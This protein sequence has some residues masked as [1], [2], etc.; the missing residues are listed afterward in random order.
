MIGKPL[1]ANQNACVHCEH[2]EVCLG[3]LLSKY[4]PTHQQSWH[5]PS[6]TY[7][8]KP[9]EAWFPYSKGTRMG[10]VLHKEIFKSN[11]TIDVVG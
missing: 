3:S 10:G 1:M 6:R 8:S 11:Y 4:I 5:H 2:I 9:L 7:L